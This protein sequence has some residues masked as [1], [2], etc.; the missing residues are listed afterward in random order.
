ME[1]DSID[2]EAHREA[3]RDGKGLTMAAEDYLDSMFVMDGHCDTVLD[4]VGLSLSTDD[5]SPRDFFA[6]GEGGHVDLPRL[7]EGGVGC[8]I[9]ALF[10]DDEYVPM[11]REHTWRLLETM[12]GVFEG[13]RGIVLARNKAEILAARAEG[14]VAGMLS[15]EGGEAIG[16]EL[17]ELGA[18]YDRGLRLMG[19]TWNRRN[20][21]GRGAGTGTPADGEGGLT[22]FGVEVLREMERL[23]MVVDASHL[24]D[25]ALDQVLDLAEG[26]VVASHSNSR[27]LVPHRR[28]LSD[29]QAER[30]AATGGLVGITFAGLFVDPDPARVTKERILE[31]LEHFLSL[32]GPDHVGIGSDFDGF[33]ERFGLGFSSPNAYRWIA[34]ELLRRGHSRPDVEKVMGGNWLRVIGEVCG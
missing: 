32:L 22:A 25:E 8:Q 18:F 1:G 27:A 21:I 13:N 4:L 15:I 5:R 19:L 24:S 33:T 26:P 12:E 28:N 14:R 7:V 11:A 10:T 3:D 30:I 34:G 29:A 2:D 6:R 16:E 17:G 9:F 23:G 31:H 20:A